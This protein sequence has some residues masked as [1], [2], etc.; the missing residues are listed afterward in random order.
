MSWS[1]TYNADLAAVEIVLEGESR[2]EDRIAAN[3]EAFAVADANNTRDFLFDCSAYERSQSTV[4]IVL[5]VESY[6]DERFRPA[7]IALVQPILPEAQGDAAFY[8]TLCVNRGWNARVF[9]GRSAAIKWLRAD[10]AG[11]P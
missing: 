7:K 5:L 11:K 2:K 1:V 6:M 4:E 10:S 8:E 3:E 9:S